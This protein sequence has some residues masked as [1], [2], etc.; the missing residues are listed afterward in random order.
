MAVDADSMSPWVLG[1][2]CDARDILESVTKALESRTPEPELNLILPPY[3]FLA[4]CKRV[5]GQRWEE[6]EKI[7]SEKRQSMIKECRERDLGYRCG[8]TAG[9]WFEALG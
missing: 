9:Q 7:V 8:I 3:S 2:R 6:D 1:K 4:E 5:R